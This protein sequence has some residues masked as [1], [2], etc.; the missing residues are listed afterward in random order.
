MLSL[1]CRLDSKFGRQR[2][3]TNPSAGC[4]LPSLDQRPLR[5]WIS[6]GPF[7]FF[8]PTDNIRLVIECFDLIIMD[9][10]VLSKYKEALIDTYSLIEIC[11]AT[12]SNLVAVD[13]L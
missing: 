1:V 5:S 8:D 10:I 9:G 2:Q 7:Y 13:R 4:G 12:D 6:G 3:S 11:I